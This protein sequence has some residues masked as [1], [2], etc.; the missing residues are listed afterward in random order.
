[1]RYNVHYYR[2]REK[3]TALGGL[4]GLLICAPLAL[5]AVGRAVYHAFRAHRREETP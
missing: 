1:M 4:L 5:V 3:R 2:R